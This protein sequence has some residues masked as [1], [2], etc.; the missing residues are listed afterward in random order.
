MLQSVVKSTSTTKRAAR[1]LLVAPLRNCSSGEDVGSTKS[2]SSESWFAP[3]FVTAT[4]Q[5]PRSLAARASSSIS[6][7]LPELEKSIATSLGL[8]AVI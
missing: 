5:A 8:A 6:V 1:R 4:T 3:Y 2:A 7:V